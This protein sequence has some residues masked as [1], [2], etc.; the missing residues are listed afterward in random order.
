MHNK[1]VKLYPSLIQLHQVLDFGMVAYIQCESEAVVLSGRWKNCP[2]GT[3]ALS[4][5][6]VRLEIARMETF[7]FLA[8]TFARV[9]V[10][11]SV[12]VGHTH[13]C[14]SLHLCRTCRQE[15]M[16]LVFKESLLQQLCGIFD[17]NSAKILTEYLHKVVVLHAGKVMKRIVEGRTTWSVAFFLRQDDKIWKSLL[18]FVV[19]LRM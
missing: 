19:F 1:I 5:L 17:Q 14:L 2:H 3:G 15:R 7:S 11:G 9:D 18:D 12:Q 10:Y 4:T 8:I 13:L 6:P 16:F